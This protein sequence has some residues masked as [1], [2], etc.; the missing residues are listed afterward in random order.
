[1]FNAL[2]DWGQTDWNIWI[3]LT[4]NATELSEFLIQQ[5]SKPDKNVRFNLYSYSIR[6]AVMPKQKW[7]IFHK[8]QQ[9]PSF[10]WQT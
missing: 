5:Y 6:W 1:M 9:V 3:Y 7:Y 10:I 4:C 8:P 2:Q